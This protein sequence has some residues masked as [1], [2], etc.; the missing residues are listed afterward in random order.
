MSNKTEVLQGEVVDNN[1]VNRHKN[2]TRIDI[3]AWV[4]AFKSAEPLLIKII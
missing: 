2:K 3:K 1:E 4:D